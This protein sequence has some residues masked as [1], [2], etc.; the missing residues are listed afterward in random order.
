[1]FFFIFGM[2]FAGRI[3]VGLTYLVEYMPYRY[4]DFGPWIILCFYPVCTILITLWY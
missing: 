3:V 1:M 2:S 4:Q